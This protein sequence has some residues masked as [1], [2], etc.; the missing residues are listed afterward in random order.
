MAGRR[1][2]VHV[3][4]HGGPG[5]TH[6][7]GPDDDLPEW[8][9]VKLADNPLVWADGDEPTEEDRETAVKYTEVVN[10]ELAQL[11]TDNEYLRGQL[12]DR[13]RRIGELEVELAG[14][15]AQ[16]PVD[17][18][19]PEE[20]DQEQ[21]DETAPE[22]EGDGLDD[23]DVEELKALAAERE[24]EIDGRWGKERLI[25]ALRADGE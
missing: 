7:F 16:V 9:E 25:E 11:R 18:T 21:P 6:T 4:V 5:G 13:D 12:T 24:V 23:L 10:E 15:R 17:E 22:E 20:P 19:A 14:V 8:A 2:K 3:S 1:L